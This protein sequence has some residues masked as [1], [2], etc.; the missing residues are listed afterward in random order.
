M[1]YAVYDATGKIVR[2]TGGILRYA[3][4][5]VRAGQNLLQVDND[6]DDRIHKVVDGKLVNK[7]PEEIEAEKAPT[8]PEIP[9]SEKPAHITN[10]QWQDVLK[11]I[12]A[13]G[14]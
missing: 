9:E 13:L 8:P 11:R 4:L 14:G 10:E 3:Q 1:K 12:E 2:I 7:T 5:Q 6:V